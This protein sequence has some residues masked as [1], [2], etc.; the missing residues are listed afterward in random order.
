MRRT[1][2]GRYSRGSGRYLSWARVKLGA[3]V[4]EGM[5]V[6][7]MVS[8]RVLSKGSTMGIRMRIKLVIVAPLSSREGG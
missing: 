8:E 3:R 5:V 1:R 2:G 4:S 6:S 7:G